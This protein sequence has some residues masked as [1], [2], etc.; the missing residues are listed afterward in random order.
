[1]FMP[2][3]SETLKEL[4]QDRFR[5]QEPMSKHTNYRLG[6]PAR[7]F[8]EAK[9]VDE[10]QKAV[11]L[12][13]EHQ[14]KIVLL[15][16]GSNV[17]VADQGIDG[18]V[19]KISIQDLEVNNNR[20]H[21]G[22]GVP[23][24]LFARKVAEHCL[25]GMEWGVTLPGTVGGAIRGNAGCF[26]GETKDYFVE[27]QVLSNGQIVTMTKEQMAFGYRESVFKH[28]Q[29]VIL[30]AVFEFEK[31]D[32]AQIQSLMDENLKKR[33]ASQPL[34]TGSAGCMFKNIEIASD[35]ELQ[36][37]QETIDLP[38]EMVSAR[39]ISAGWI[40]DQLD[41]KGKQ[42]GGAKVSEKHGNFLL[43]TGNATSDDM[44]QLIAF[45]KTRARNTFG[46]QL[47]EEV[48]YLE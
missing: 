29:D 41:L 24:V 21:V 47:Q 1:M 4:F 22:A 2:Q 26:G 19:I 37:I 12:A 8:V 14:V 36:R 35:E 3:F 33:K 40:I 7:F 17:L 48:Q 31:G 28:S 30:S 11:D 15:G 42:I 10:V 5:E 20:V 9:T 6:G 45:I 32:C 34:E 46:I 13:K 38:S 25:K 27:A 39:R 23:M 44:M 18:L 16:G 43:N